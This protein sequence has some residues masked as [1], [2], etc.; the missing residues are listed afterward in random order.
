MKKTTLF[1]MLLF[2]FS[3]GRVDKIETV[4][5]QIIIEEIKPLTEEESWKLF[6]EFWVEFQN[7]IINNDTNRIKVLCEFE[8]KFTTVEDFLENIPRIKNYIKKIDKDNN[9]YYLKEF[10][11]TV[12]G[13]TFPY[14][15]KSSIE[16]LKENNGFRI[17][18]RIRTGIKTKDYIPHKKYL[19]NDIYTF[20]EDYYVIYVLIFGLI[21]GNYKLTYFNKDF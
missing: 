14:I 19:I 17:R 20:N 2:L 15:E 8:S 16:Y 9:Y 10:D 11:K 21:N 18:I 13:I 7:C 4:E 3:C 12:G 1:I 5:E 6:D